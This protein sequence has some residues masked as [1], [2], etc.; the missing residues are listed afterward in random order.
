VLSQE[1]APQT[2]STVR[3]IA[4]E[5]H[6]HPSVYTAVLYININ[7]NSTCNKLNYIVQRLVQLT[8]NFNI[9]VNSA[10]LK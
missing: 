3:Q 9:V 7:I 10:Y 4:R 1:D 6:V 8:Y 2:H 5:T